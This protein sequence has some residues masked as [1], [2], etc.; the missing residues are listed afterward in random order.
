[1]VVRESDWESGL[2]K[3]IKDACRR[4]VEWSRKIN[5]DQAAALRFYI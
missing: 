2:K 1:M 5:G 3:A 4:A